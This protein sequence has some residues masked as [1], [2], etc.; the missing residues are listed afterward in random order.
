MVH[1]SAVVNTHNEEKNLSR[2]LQAVYGLVE[3]IVVVD[4]GSAD[5]TRDIAKKFNAKVFNHPYVGYVEPARNFALEKAKGKWILLLDADEVINEFLL[6]KLINL[7][8]SESYDYFRI[9]RQNIIF[10]TWIEHSN[11]WPDYQIRFFRKGSVEWD[12]AIHSIPITTGSGFDLPPE[13]KNALIHYN[14]ESISQYIER[15][16][17]YTSIEAHALAENGYQFVPIHILQ[18]PFSEFLIRFFASDG[19]KDGFHG[20]ILALLQSISVFVVYAK[21]WEAQKKQGQINQTALLNIIGEELYK[22][23]RALLYWVYTKKAEGQQSRSKR[24]L[25]KIRMK[26]GL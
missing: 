7:S 8:K 1:I 5:K 23:N 2:C 11:W 13:E 25:Y 15:L 21:I 22:M 12:N 17:R 19:Y 16:N 6:K 3:E 10:G 9:P 4:M 14:Y 20:L 18:K 26:I 24:L